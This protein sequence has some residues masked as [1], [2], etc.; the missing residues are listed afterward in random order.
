MDSAKSA[1]DAAASRIQSKADEA[2]RVVEEGVEGVKE[3][4]KGWLGWGASKKDAVV[5]RAAEMKEGAKDGLLA[6]EKKVER[7][8]QKAQE[9][10]K[11]M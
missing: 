11:K 3:T 1:V 8:A 9:Q 10:T 5:D 7:G 2:K 6:A 4:G